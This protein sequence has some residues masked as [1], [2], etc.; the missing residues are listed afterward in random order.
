MSE[1]ANEYKR[2]DGSA[3]SDADGDREVLGEIPGCES[4]VD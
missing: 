4:H 2:G 3:G 1:R